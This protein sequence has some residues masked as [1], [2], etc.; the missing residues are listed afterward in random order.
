VRSKGFLGL[1]I[2]PGLMQ[3]HVFCSCSGRTRFSPATFPFTSSRMVKTKQ[4][5]RCAADAVGAILSFSI[6]A[7]HNDENYR[8]RSE[9]ALPASCTCSCR[10]LSSYSRLLRDTSLNPSYYGRRH[11][12]R[13]GIIAT[14]DLQA[15]CAELYENAVD[16]AR[17]ETG[18]L[19]FRETYLVD[20]R[21]FSQLE[22]RK[23]KATL[24]SP[25]SPPRG[26]GPSTGPA[27]AARPLSAFGGFFVS[28]RFCSSFGHDI[29]YVLAQREVE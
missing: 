22:L 29:L 25:C 17:L 15:A 20:A 8:S 1:V 9:K 16:R 28:W 4:F 27:H 3:D 26:T 11:I 23:V 12:A 7:Y 14:Y 18:R 2:P 19:D 5:A 24:G 13:Q 21:H 10:S 6:V